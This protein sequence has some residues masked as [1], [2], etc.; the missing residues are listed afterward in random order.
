[1]AYEGN[2]ISDLDETKPDGTVEKPHV[3]DNALRE[4]K[5]ALK[6]MQLDH[7]NGIPSVLLNPGMCLRINS[8][9]SGFEVYDAYNEIHGG[10]SHT[11]EYAPADHTHGLDGT[12]TVVFSIVATSSQL[13]S[14]L[15]VGELR[16]TADNR[17]LY[18]WNGSEWILQNPLHNVMMWM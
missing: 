15:T 4:I 1:M 9:G 13:G 18:M 6:N 14:G 3:V 11:G 5:R 12:S 2:Y 10:H 16:I 7:I 17:N 8:A